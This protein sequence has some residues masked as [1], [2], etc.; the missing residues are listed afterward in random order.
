MNPRI[1]SPVAE[2]ISAVQG[3]PTQTIQI[4]SQ[5]TPE[6]SEFLQKLKEAHTIANQNP[7]QLD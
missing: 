6:V 2:K 5:K 1:G 7:F 4:S 3:K